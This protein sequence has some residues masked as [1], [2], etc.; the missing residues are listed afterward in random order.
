MSRISLNNRDIAPSNANN[1][2]S[3]QEK[4]A[5]IVEYLK[6]LP[7]NVT[8]NN[9]NIFQALGISLDDDM[10]LI[11]MLKSNPKVST[12]ILV[13]ETNTPY[14]YNFQYVRPYSIKYCD[15]H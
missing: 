13:D 11:D 3:P 5:D 1:D 2:Q 7:T 9:Y 4:H 12:E 8:A 15:C 14:S 6:N 10:Y